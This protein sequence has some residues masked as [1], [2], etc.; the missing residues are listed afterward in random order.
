AGRLAPAWPRRAARPSGLAIFALG[1]ALALPAAAVAPLAPSLGM[2]L[3]DVLGAWLFYA[4]FLL[5]VGLALRGE[6]LLPIGAGRPAGGIT[7][8]LTAAGVGFA[9]AYALLSS[10]GRLSP[11]LVPTPAPPHRGR[12][13]LRRRL[14]AA[15]VA[16]RPLAPSRPHARARVGGRGAQRPAAAA[17]P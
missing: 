11:H 9:G 4:G 2:E 7:R 14:R 10:P 17:V 8:S 6:T 15:L 16:G 13:G 1:L 12:R 5:A 3:V